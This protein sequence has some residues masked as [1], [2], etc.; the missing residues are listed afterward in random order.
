[1]KSCPYRKDFYAKLISDPEG[2][3]PVPRERLNADLDKWL[4]ALDSIVNRMQ[5]FFTDGR[6]DKGF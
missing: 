5:K 4:A 6:H 2:G 1:M 3:E